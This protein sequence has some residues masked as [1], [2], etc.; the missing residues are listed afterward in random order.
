MAAHNEYV[1][2]P[3]ETESWRMGS[4]VKAAVLERLALHSRLTDLRQQQKQATVEQRTKRQGGD[5]KG[6]AAALAKSREA[7]SEIRKTQAEIDALV[8][9][10][11]KLVGGR[12]AKQDQPLT[13]DEIARAAP[14]P[15]AKGA[16]VESA[17]PGPPIVKPPL[18]TPAA[19]EPVKPPPTGEKPPPTEA[20]KPP[21]SK[22]SGLKTPATPPPLKLMSRYGSRAKFV[23]VVTDKLRTANRGRPPG[24]ERVIEAL[25]ANRGPNNTEILVKIEKVMDA[26][27]NHELLRK[28]A[29]GRVGSGQGR[30]GD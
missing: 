12:I 20:A 26:L 18:V 6:A 14:E 23:K 21:A 30:H 17:E 1:A 15:E 4:A 25:N 7:Q 19:S 29:R 13:P 27:Q 28:G 24:W 16:A 10:E 11:P 5:R 8:S 2:L 9:K 22:G 3:E